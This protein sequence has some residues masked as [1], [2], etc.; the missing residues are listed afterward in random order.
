MTIVSGAPEACYSLFESV[1]NVLH[2]LKIPFFDLFVF[3][4]SKFLK[5]LN[6]G[7]PGIGSD[8]VA[9]SSNTS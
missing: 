2:N 5:F 9:S 3:F 1:E 4:L 7:V 6:E 8:A